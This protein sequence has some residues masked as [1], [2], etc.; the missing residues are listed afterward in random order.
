[1]EVQWCCRP[2][3]LA[4]VPRTATNNL[5]GAPSSR[6]EDRLMGIVLEAQDLVKTYA[7]DGAAPVEALRGISLSAA[8]GEFVVIAGA[9]GSGK[10]TLLTVLAGLEPPTAGTIKIDGREITFATED[11]L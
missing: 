6:G 10:S 8:A 11:E 1:M 7:R 9:S 3:L 2:P 4:P 5:P